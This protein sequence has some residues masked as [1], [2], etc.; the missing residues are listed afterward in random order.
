MSARPTYLDE[1]VAERF[2]SLLHPLLAPADLVELWG[3]PTE[4]EE[5]RG[6]RL[7]APSPL[8]LW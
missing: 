2:A 3:L 6:A 8:A 5:R 1:P 4:H 7:L